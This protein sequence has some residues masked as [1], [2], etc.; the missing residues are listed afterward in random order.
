MVIVITRGHLSNIV[1]NITSEVVT[2]A[3]EDSRVTRTR[4]KVSVECLVKVM[5]L[6][7]LFARVKCI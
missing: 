5:T 1:S 2:D 4:D 7:F 6:L 3:M